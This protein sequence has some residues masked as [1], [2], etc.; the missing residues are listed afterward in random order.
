MNEIQAWVAPQTL[1]EAKALASVIAASELA[2]PHRGQPA[3]VLMCMLVSNQI[4]V[5]LM[6]VLQEVAI[7]NNRPAIWGTLLME[8]AMRHPK[9]VDFDC[10]VTG[11]GM[12][13]EGWF[14]IVYLNG[15]G[16]KAS[17]TARFTMKDAQTAGLID[18]KGG[19]YKLYSADMLIS[20]ARSRALRRALPG[21]THGL[22]TKEEMEDAVASRKS[23]MAA[24]AVGA[25]KLDKLTAQIVQ[26]DAVEA[27][28]PDPR[29]AE[30][31]EDAS[32][33]TSGQGDLFMDPLKTEAYERIAAAPD[34]EAL[35]AVQDWLKTVVL[36]SDDA[37]DVRGAIKDRLYEFTT[38]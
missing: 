11:T 3:N 18:K 15:I 31:P 23:T 12:E 10:G 6:Q 27:T 33:T 22:A 2:G 1:D 24:P 29:P 4:Q 8:L 36:S 35:F 38:G 9:Y 19:I 5:G 28:L 25:G 14:T 20:R 32:W 16:E 37:A 34:E 26:R 30:V 17:Y 21:C 7:I 13:M